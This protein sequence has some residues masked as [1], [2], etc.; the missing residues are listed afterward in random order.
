MSSKGGRKGQRTR[1]APGS[2]TRKV[3]AQTVARVLAGNSLDTLLEEALARVSEREQGFLRELATGAVRHAISLQADIDRFLREPLRPRDRD[4]LA[5]LLVGA[6]QLRNLRVPD[7]AAIDSCV[8]AARGT[9]KPWAPGLVNAVLRKV[10]ASEAPQVHN[11]PEWLVDTLREDFPEDWEHLLAVSDSRAPMTLRINPRRST[12]TAYLQALAAAGLEG[13]TGELGTGSVVLTEAVSQTTL[14]HNSCGLFTIQDE[15]AQLAGMLLQAACAN[16]GRLLDACAAPGGKASDLLERWPG[17]EHTFLEVDGKRLAMT[18]ERLRHWPGQQV[19][20]IEGDACDPDSWWDGHAFDA[21]LVDAPCSGTGSLRRNPDIRLLRRA[22]DIPNLAQLQRS[23][24]AALWPLLAP[25]G[26]L[27]YVTCSLLGEENEDVVE[28]FLESEASAS[29]EPLAVPNA[30]PRR[31]G[32][33][34]PPRAGA[35]DGFYF[36]LLRKSK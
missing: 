29:V 15:G 24:L 28:A 3:A 35:N 20:W 7:F 33:L 2:E 23:M 36:A 9:R 18:R 12:P 32:M 10:A 14:P 6:H 25:G 4:V 22:S 17:A 31:T 11:A 30:T 21:I 13:T 19:R 26:H 34:L 1:Q 16:P 8:S 27:L 5:C